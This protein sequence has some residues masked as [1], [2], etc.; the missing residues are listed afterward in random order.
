[1]KTVL[2]SR[3]ARNAFRTIVDALEWPGGAEAIAVERGQYAESLH[4]S[5]RLSIYAKD[6]PGTVF[7]DTRDESTI[8]VDQGAAVWLQG[9]VIRNFHSEG[10]AVIAWDALMLDRCQLIC[11]G[12]RGLYAE[13]ASASLRDCR[14]EHCGIEYLNAVGTVE[15]T[16]IVAPRG[17]GVVVGTGANPVVRQTAIRDPA[18]NGVLVTAGGTGTFEDCEITGADE[19]S[20]FCVAMQGAPTVRRLRVQDGE[21]DGMLFDRGLGHVEDSV[22]GPIG[23]SGI[24]LMKGSSVTIKGTRVQRSGTAGIG[25]VERSRAVIEDCEVIGVDG[26]GIVVQDRSEAT[27]RACRIAEATDDGAWLTTRGRGRFEAVAVLAS[28]GNGL[29]ASSGAELTLANCTVLD[30][31]G[32]AV[33]RHDDATVHVTGLTAMRNRGGDD[34]VIV[35]QTT[36]QAGPAPYRSLTPPPAPAA[37]PEDVDAL[38][39]ELDAMV[40][41]DGVKREVRAQVN[42]VKVNEQRRRAGLPVPSRGMHLVFMGPP[43]TGK[44]SVARLY[45]RLLSALGVMP[46]GQFVEAARAD[47]VSNHVGET[48]LKT[49]EKFDQAIGGVLFIDE[50]YTLSRQFGS[51]GDFGQEAIDALVKLMEDHRDR[52]AVIVAGYAP[53]MRHFLAANPGLRS[54]FPKTIQF[55][56][57]SPEEL[58]RIVEGMAGQYQFQLAAGARDLLVGHFQRAR[59]DA[60]F[61]NGREARRV[62]DAIVERQAARIATLP[63]VSEDDL[64]MLVPADL[65]GVVDSGASRLEAEP[66]DPA[67]V[68]ALLAEL[69][70]MV[71]LDAVKHDIRTLLDL[72][73]DYRRR[74]AAG[75]PAQPMTGHLVFAGPPGTGKTTV[76]RLYGR[77]LAALG[78]IAQGQ[79]VEVTRADLVAG[80]VGQTALK[81]RETFD[82]ARGGVLFID[83]AYALARRVGEAAS[84]FGLEAID[85]LVKLMDDHRDEVVVIAAGYSDDMRAFL[86]ANEGLASRFSRVLTFEPYSPDELLAIFDDMAAAA[87]D[88]ASEP[89]EAALRAH[90]HADRGGYAN[91]NGRDV[92]RLYEAMVAGRSRRLAR[93]AEAGVEPTREELRAFQP[94]DV[95]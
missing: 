88:A 50:A 28:G 56:N 67:H 24:G 90:F 33:A 83:E 93:R 68:Q 80:F 38:L 45:G 74:R 55:E 73:A 1:M 21:A 84:D 43:G 65:D 77:L 63:T 94:E 29:L 41:L 5:G 86:A 11:Q 23:G 82:R 17:N 66:R 92:R 51:G 53:E 8:Y 19:V 71:G 40:G 10:I 85:T 26:I 91:G 13:R 95:A 44:T 12:T 48:A 59:R 75:L 79:V 34:I 2:V 32:A 76:A 22:I 16:E 78:V 39:A 4:I 6:G 69:D 15:R 14:L 54:R 7:I 27:V 70:R 52:L 46:N 47:L 9:L 49:T 36:V 25:L 18:G 31:R 35:N 61:G 57:Y 64:R 60:T 58:V 89:V 72:I 42:L 3:T 62:F 81:T 30:N 37:G 20:A 87:D